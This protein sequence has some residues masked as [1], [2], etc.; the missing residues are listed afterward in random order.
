MTVVAGYVPNPL[1]EAV[2]DA[3][4]EQARFRG[5]NVVVV[6]TTRADRLVDPRYAQ[7]EPLELMK[8]RLDESG[9][10][11]AVRHFTSTD[12]AAEDL[13]QVA[14][15]VT[16]DLVVIGVRHRTPVGKLLLGSTA[17]SV[18]LQAQ[19]PVLAVKHG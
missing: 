8:R 13:L 3:A 15:E 7:G 17:Q 18:L 9:V 2:L 19:C 4:I 12:T 6:N 11:Y 14:Q 10:Q 16:A 5:T 1:G